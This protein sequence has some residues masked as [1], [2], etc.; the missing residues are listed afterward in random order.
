MIIYTSKIR[1]CLNV[2]SGL[3]FQLIG[4]IFC[5]IPNKIN[6]NKEFKDSQFCHMGK[7]QTN[8]DIQSVC[9]KTNTIRMVKKKLSW[10]NRDKRENQL[11]VQI[12]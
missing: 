2:L 6:W 4:K 5:G 1:F 12:L 11:K 7:L 10:W 9:F 3:K 8:F